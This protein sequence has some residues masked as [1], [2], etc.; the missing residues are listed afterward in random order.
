MMGRLMKEYSD[1]SEHFMRVTITDENDGSLKNQKYI[2]KG[3]LKSM[4][5]TIGILNG[6]YVPLI[7]TSFFF[8]LVHA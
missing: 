2:T 6:E 3:S 4:M 8:S 5:S 7:S 1:Q